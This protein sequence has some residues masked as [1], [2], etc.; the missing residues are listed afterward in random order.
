MILKLT[1]IDYASLD[2]DIQNLF[3]NINFWYVQ[4]TS[5]LLIT[6]KLYA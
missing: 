2:R 5:N 1:T 3:K 6:F 4:V